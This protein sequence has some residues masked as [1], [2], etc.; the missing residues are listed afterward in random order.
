MGTAPLVDPHT[1]LKG[2]IEDNMASPDGVW[3]PTVNDGWLKVKKQKTF[4]ISIVGGYADITTA[5]LIPVGGAIPTIMEQFFYVTLYAPTRS[6]IWS[7]YRAFATVMNTA[8]L[9]TFGV[10][11]NTDY[12]F[13]KITR[14]DDAKAVKSLDKECG[15]DDPPKGDQMGYRMDISV[16][17]RWDE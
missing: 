1:L 9:T 13:A 8:S 3:T 17:V 12:R 6:A 15:F 16:L 4:Q 14:S 10:N 7:L 11:G 2:L 5:N